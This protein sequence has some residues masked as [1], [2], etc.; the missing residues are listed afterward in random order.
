M[1]TIQIIDKPTGEVLATVTYTPGDAKAK[2]D[3]PY[4]RFR[5][6][7]SRAKTYSGFIGPEG[8][9]AYMDALLKTFAGGYVGSVELPAGGK[10]GDSHG[11][12]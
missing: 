12:T 8:G 10:M 9:D 1:R 5:S 3:T 7:V 4:E 6:S 11:G 2:I